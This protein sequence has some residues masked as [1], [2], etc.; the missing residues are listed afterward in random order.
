MNDL[1]YGK[2]NKRGDWAPAKPVS[3]L[4]PIYAFPPKL[5]AVLKWL[6]EYIAPWNLLIAAITLAYW[7]WVVPSVEVM[8]SFQLGWVLWLYAVNAIGV[9]LFFGVFELRLY[10]QR[11]QGARFKYNA[12]F[13]SD[14]PSDVFWFQSQNR[15]NILRTFAFGVTIW[16]A[17]QACMLWAYANG[18]A[19]WMSWAEN[20]IWLAVLF[21]LVPV[22]HEAH[23]YCIHRLIHMPFLYKHVHSVHHNSVNPSPW[24]SLSMHPVEHVLYFGVALW[25]LILPSHPVIMLFQL[26]KA[27]YGAVTG[28]V[29]FDKIELGGDRILDTH[30]YAHYL[31]HKY[32]EVNY[33]DGLVPFDSLFGTWHDGSKEGD[34]LMQERHRAKKQRAQ[35]Q[36]AKEATL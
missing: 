26:H 5:G 24:S 3:G 20:P 17:V 13:P 16:T 14:A 30:A 1:D 28:H 2:R 34:A 12:K 10:M 32:F 31:H 6:P 33:G 25:H 19:P 36:A 11:Q 8:Q 18:Y 21:L 15:D 27:G 9:F 23:F 7:L 22:I 35:A 29:G 4:A